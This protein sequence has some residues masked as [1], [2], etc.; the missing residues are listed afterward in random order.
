[1]LDSYAQHLVRPLVNVAV[2]RLASLGVAPNQV[3]IA[4][5]AMGVA[6]AVAFYAGLHWSAVLLIVAA[7]VGDLLDGAL[8]RETGRTTPLGGLLD[9]WLD[10]L[11]EVS[12]L[13]AY[14]LVFPDVR[15]AI[16]VLACTIILSLTVFLTMG[17]LTDNDGHKVIPYQPGIAERAET[18]IFFALFFAFPALRHEWVYLFAALIALTVVQRL[19]L[20]WK[21]LR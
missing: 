13:V 18:I 17:A 4:S 5:A 15:L 2:R 11:V 6:S 3:T 7:G 19:Y 16:V 12:V 10:R 8:A 1:V 14:A 9:L 20:A 21:T